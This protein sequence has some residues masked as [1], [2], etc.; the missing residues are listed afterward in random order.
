MNQRNSLIDPVFVRGMTQRRVSRR[1]AFR[2]GGLT[3]VGA[4]LAACGVSGAGKKTTL[5]QAQSAAKKFWTGKSK[6]GH[7]NFANWPL[8]IDTGHKTLKEFTK[9]TGI[10]VN[11]KEVIQ[12]DSSWFAKISPQI[13]SGSYIGYDVMVVTDGFEFSELVALGELVPLN[14]GMLTNFYSNASQKYKHRSFDPGNTYSIPWAS[15]STGIAWNP[16]YIKTPVTSI[17][18]LW[19][20]AY[21]GHVGMMSD[22]Q[23]I[24]NFGMIKLG[25][26]PEKSTAADWHKAASALLQQ[27]NEGIVRQY[28][29]QSYINALTKGDTWITMA[30]SGDIF[31]QNLSSGSHLKFV[32]PDEGGNIWT[33][34]M[35]IPKYAQNPVDAMMVMDWFY[36]PGIAAQLT[37]GINY[38][39]AVPA[40]KSIIE[41]DAAKAKGSDKATLNDVA[42]STLVWPSQAV[43]KRLF[44]YVSVTGQKKGE[45]Q[46]IF[47]PVVAG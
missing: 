4:G 10:T 46:S 11:Y 25:I 12:D 35:M 41:S 45:F 27:R 18:E 38:I 47:Q 19:N 32:I 30:W 21:K 24:G 42:N 1:D 2:I 29:D 37:E 28:Y 3:A 39:T 17:K 5:T 22:V 36:R 8:Y 6:H 34:N 44:N 23:E 7:V 13:R 15:G 16:K 9:A 14:Q 43:Y 26:D 33:D 20:P 31:Q 40:A